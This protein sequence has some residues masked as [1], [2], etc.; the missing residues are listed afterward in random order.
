M[1][2]P[3]HKDPPLKWI[4]ENGKEVVSSNR[5]DIEAMAS[6]ARQ[7]AET[8]TML[9][10]TKTIDAEHHSITT[11]VARLETLH[12]TARNYSDCVLQAVMD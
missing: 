12:S 5:A 4:D 1:A 7:I 2:R 3:L 9:L 10:Q 11:V 6:E 8:L